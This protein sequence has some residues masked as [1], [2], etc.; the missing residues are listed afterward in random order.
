M[1]R[2][3][4]RHG[5]LVYTFNIYWQD[6]E[7]DMYQLVYQ[8][9]SSK[10]YMVFGDYSVYHHGIEYLGPYI[11]RYKFE[12]RHM[13]SNVATIP[14]KQAYF[15][16]AGDILSEIQE[17]FGLQDSILSKVLTNDMRRIT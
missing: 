3:V 11:G 16:F 7:E 10:L 5:Q 1:I 4:V 2:G 13:E 8:T 12:E 14:Y 6:P 15:M 17:L 9:D